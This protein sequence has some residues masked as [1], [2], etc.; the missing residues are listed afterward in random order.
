[1]GSRF[2][3]A[4]FI[5]RFSIGMRIFGKVAIILVVLATR[6]SAQPAEISSGSGVVIGSHGEVLTNAHVVK[7]CTR[8]TVR[9]SAQDSA[10]ALVLARDDK[11]DLAV[12]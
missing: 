12:C 1:M 6:A 9:S 4:K 7:Q 11:N 5:S 8:I 3:G 2:K 10:V